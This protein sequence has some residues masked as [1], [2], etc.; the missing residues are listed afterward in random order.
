MHALPG[1]GAVRPRRD[2]FTIGPMDAIEPDDADALAA[3]EAWHRGRIAELTAEE[4]WLTLVGLEWLDEGE[5]RVGADAD[6]MPRLPGGGFWGTLR[7]AGASVRPAAEWAPADG[8][9]A[10]LE[11]DRDGHPAIVRRGRLSFFLIERDGRLAMRVRDADA[12]ARRDFAGIARFPYAPAWRLTAHWDGEVA[13]FALAGREFGLRPQDPGAAR[14]QFV[15]AD[16]TSG[17]ETYGGG[18][19][20]FADRPAPGGVLVLDFNRA[21]NPPCAFTPFAVCPLPPP[22]N[23]LPLAVPAGERAWRPAQA[24]APVR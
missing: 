15:V 17:R 13:R 23:R 12:P 4:G 2:W 14:L 8:P 3:H 16:A 11:T 10:A 24:P 9:P 1:R 19:F 7:V 6:C 22:E 5:Y 20:L 21:L 18:R